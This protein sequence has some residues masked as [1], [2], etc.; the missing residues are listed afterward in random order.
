[1]PGP[2]FIMLSYKMIL[3]N[4]REAKRKHMS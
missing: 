3:I 1:M 2:L 4:Y